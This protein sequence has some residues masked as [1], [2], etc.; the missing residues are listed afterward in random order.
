LNRSAARRSR[1]PQARRSTAVIFQEKIIGRMLE[2]FL[3]FI[4]ETVTGRHA[5]G[6]FDES[7][8][9]LAAAALLIHIISLDGEPSEDEMRKLRS[10]LAYRFN[11]DDADARRLIEAAAAAE[12]ES[13]DL[14]LF[15]SRINRDVDAAGRA[16]IVEMM[17]EMV[18]ADDRV[19]EMEESVVWRAA[20]LLG[21]SS[22]ERVDLKRRVASGLGRRK[23]NGENGKEDES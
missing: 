3:N 7:D 4:T 16:R 10:L 2:K 22:R 15:T 23:E 17:W 8:Y 5:D 14:Y 12:D 1:E 6:R 19:S 9:R 18:F 20:D 21:I 13:V 11:L